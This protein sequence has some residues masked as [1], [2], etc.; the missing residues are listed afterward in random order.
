MKNFGLKFIDIM[1]GV[2]LGL[3][4]QWWPN[5]T[6][7]WQYAAF[8]FAYI[9]IVDYWID[10]A[11]SLKRFPPKREIDLMLDV[12]IIFTLFL[13]IYSTQL[14][15]V[16]FFLAFV[17]FRVFDTLWSVRA[18]REYD[19]TNKDTLY[20]RT[21]SKLNVCEMALT[22]FAVYVNYQWIV[23]PALLLTAYIVFR[24]ITRTIAGFVYGRLHLSYE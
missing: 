4:F 15:I 17:L 16:Y 12:A 10:Y 8:I 3:G 9:D 6:N 21:W 7:G 18:L 2:V 5:L 11:A 19:L 13:Y 1:V 20:L 14:T 24:I 23:D 22:L